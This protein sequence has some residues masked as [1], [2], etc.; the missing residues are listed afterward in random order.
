MSL[1]NFQLLLLFL[2]VHDDVCDFEEVAAGVTQMLVVSESP[3]LVKRNEKNRYLQGDQRLHISR[4][5]VS[6]LS[7]K[8][9]SIIRVKVYASGIEGHLLPNFFN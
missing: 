4:L 6:M 8:F 5:S 2:L 7:S 9:C 1:F 3:N